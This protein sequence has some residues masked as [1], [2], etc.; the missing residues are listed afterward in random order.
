MYTP[1]PEVQKP[2]DVFVLE[3]SLPS[4]SVHQGNTTVVGLP[5]VTIRDGPAVAVLFVGFSRLIGL[6]KALLGLQ[7]TTTMNQS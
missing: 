3:T 4:V 2:R 7:I 6:Q 1:V 5:D